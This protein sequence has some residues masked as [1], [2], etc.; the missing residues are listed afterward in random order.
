MDSRWGRGL[1]GFF[2][3]GLDRNLWKNYYEIGG[4]KGGSS[5]ARFRGESCTLP[6]K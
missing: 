4:A 3:L 2:I 5:S 1:S 6:S